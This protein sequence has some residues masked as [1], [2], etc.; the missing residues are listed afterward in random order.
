MHE[1]CDSCHKDY[2]FTKDTARLVLFLNYL[3]ASH[4]EAKCPNCGAKE[5]IYL[6]TQSFLHVLEECKLGIAFGLEPTDERRE[7]CD[8]TWGEEAKEDEIEPPKEISVP[9][10]MLRELFDDLRNWRG[11]PLA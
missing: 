8:A 3:R 2:A 9:H 5:I 11:E 10:W 1:N 6:T 4:V 7:A